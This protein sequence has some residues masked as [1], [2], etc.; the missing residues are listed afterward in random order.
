M[1]PLKHEHRYSFQPLDE[2]QRVSYESNPHVIVIGLMIEER[3]DPD[4]PREIPQASQELCERCLIPM[5][6]N[7][8]GRLF[9]EICRNH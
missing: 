2:T 3:Y 9:C 5:I 1:G 6:R 8:D 4:N 7:E